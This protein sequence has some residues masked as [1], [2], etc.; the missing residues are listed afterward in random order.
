MAKIAFIG[1]GSVGFTRRLFADIFTVPEL[2]DSRISF[3]DINESYLDIAKK[4]CTKDASENGLNMPIEI[5]TDRRKALDGADYVINTARIGLLEGLRLDTDIPAK[6]GVLQ[7]V[8]D[9]L[10]A[11]GIMY[12]Q[13]GIPFIL[14]V[15][16]DIR[17]VSAEKALLINYGNPMAMM[18]WAAAQYGGINVVGLCHGVQGGHALIAKA[19]D[20]PQEEIDIVCAGIN[21]QT[22]YIGV[23]HRGTDLTGSLL[24]AFQSDPEIKDNEPVRIDMLKRFGYFSTESNGHLSEYLPW[25]R[26]NEAEISN[27]VG[28]SGAFSNGNTRAYLEKCFERRTEYEEHYE[29]WLNEPSRK[30]TEEHRSHEHGSHIIEALETGRTYRGHFNAVNG[31]RITNLPED[32][33]IEAPGYVDRTGIHTPPVGELPPGCAA[34]CNSSISVQR[35]SVLAAVNGDDSLLRQAMLMDPLVGAVCTTKQVWEMVDELLVANKEWLPQYSKAISR[36]EKR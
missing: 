16:K 8:A 14:D 13:R 20:I 35:L 31:S 26:K 12:G 22:W 17:E 30:F 11:G 15:A 28:V 1:A 6:Y 33:I 32:A 29:E 4:L 21:H 24:S 9:T 34:V 3:M 23:T 27:W 25:Y 19:L 10:S 7:C 36:I 18:T 5:T 2:R